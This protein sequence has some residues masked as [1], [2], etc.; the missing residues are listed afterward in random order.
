MI[1]GLGRAM[2]CVH[3]W[4]GERENTFRIFLPLIIHEVKS[5][6]GCVEKTY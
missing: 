3:I 5:H 6:I 2:L 1:S 4:P